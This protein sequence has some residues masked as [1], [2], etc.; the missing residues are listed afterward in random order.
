MTTLATPPRITLSPDQQYAAERIRGW[1]KGDA[2]ELT[3]GGYAGCG[4]TTVLGYLREELEE[5]QTLFMAPSAKAAFVLNTKGIKACTVHSAIYLY[6]G[7]YVNWRDQEVPQFNEREDIKCDFE[8]KRF[9]VDESSMVNKQMCLDIRS[10]GLQICWAG[11]HGQLPPVG[12]D[13]GLMKN[14]DVKLEVIHRQSGDSPI[15]T[16]A[17]A[18]R[19]GGSPTMKHKAAGSVDVMAL[20]HPKSIAEYAVKHNYDQIL[21]GFNQTRHD[22]NRYMREALG[23]KGLLTTGD[24]IMCTFND[25]KRFCFNGMAF[26][27]MRIHEETEKHFLCDLR[28]DFGGELG[29]WRNKVPVQ[30]KSL[31]NPNY[32]TSE[33]EPSCTEFEYGQ[34]ATVHKFQGSS[35]PS[36]LLV[37]QQ[38]RNWSMARW[39]YTG[40]TR[41]EQRIGIAL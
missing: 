23:L 19:Q 37:W 13:P 24:K 16:L 12:D 30:K 3:F 10:K 26:R 14:P 31:G 7:S 22:L 35:A 17:H 33:R 11:D 2:H 25:R 32:K 36:V 38:C 20:R 41:A 21:V 6:A 18:I 1:L 9:V 8:P 28:I 27:V 39:G 29:S 4:K 34:A 5:A 40:V 15:L